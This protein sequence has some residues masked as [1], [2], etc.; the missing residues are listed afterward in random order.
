MPIDYIGAGKIVG[1]LLNWLPHRLAPYRMV[2]AN[3]Q[4][5]R[6]TAAIFGPTSQRCA[7]VI[8]RYM[9]PQHNAD[10]FKV[11][12]I[13]GRREAR[14]GRECVWTGTVS[15]GSVQEC[16]LVARPAEGGPGTAPRYPSGQ[17]HHYAS[18]GHLPWGVNGNAVVAVLERNAESRARLLDDQGREW[19]IADPAGDLVIVW[20]CMGEKTPPPW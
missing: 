11:V 12:R 1:S 8:L 17:A 9:L 14:F 4:E 18:P 13:R 5:D 19:R 7:R 10:G 2:S 16:V 3:V 6:I 20:R 15:D